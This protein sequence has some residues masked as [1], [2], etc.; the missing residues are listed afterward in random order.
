MCTSTSDLL[1]VKEVL[2][3]LYAYWVST[4]W[5]YSTIYYRYHDV[6]CFFVHMVRQAQSLLFDLVK[7]FHYI[8]SSH[9]FDIFIRKDLYSFM[10]A[11]HVMSYHL[12]WYHGTKN[13]ACALVCNSSVS[14]VLIKEG[15]L[16]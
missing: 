13:H 6:L 12:T 16:V 2:T 10:R 3:H 7:A 9:K 14:I 15:S 8:E 1:Y 5:T 11:Q 4:S